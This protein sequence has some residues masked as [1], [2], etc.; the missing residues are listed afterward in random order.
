MKQDRKLVVVELNEIN[1]YLIKNTLPRVIFQTL[2][3]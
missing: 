2:K 1:F 3:N